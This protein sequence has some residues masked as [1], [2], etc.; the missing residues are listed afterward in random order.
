[1]ELSSSRQPSDRSDSGRERSADAQAK[2]EEELL[3]RVLS[4][5]KAKDSTADEEERIRRNPSASQKS[6]KKKHRRSHPP[7]PNEEAGPDLDGGIHPPEPNEEGGP[8]PDRADDGGHLEPEGVDVHFRRIAIKLEA[9][10]GDELLTCSNCNTFGIPTTISCKLPGK[11]RSENKAAKFDLAFS[12]ARSTTLSLEWLGV[13]GSTETRFVWVYPHEAARSALSAAR[14]Y[15]A[16]LDKMCREREEPLRTAVE[17]HRAKGIKRIKGIKGIDK[18]RI[19]EVLGNPGTSDTVD[20]EEEFRL[21][22]QALESMERLCTIGGYLY[23]GRREM[24][25][26]THYKAHLK[27]AFLAAEVKAPTAPAGGVPEAQAAES[28]RYLI[29]SNRCQITDSSP[30]P[31]LSAELKKLKPHAVRVTHLPLFPEFAT[32]ATPHALPLTAPLGHGPVISGDRAGSEGSQR[33]L[34]R[35]GASVPFNFPA[36]AQRRFTV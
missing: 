19:L 2:D 10:T 26:A 36:A 8:D 29:Y 21:R 23:F 34:L 27:G 20:V 25:S 31:E 15:L 24:V 5:S 12:E 13:D 30:E 22:M 14:E 35:V 1:M 16:S 7:E 3:R 6:K 32:R 17:V 18:K 4:A 11:Y 9:L 28:E 33:A